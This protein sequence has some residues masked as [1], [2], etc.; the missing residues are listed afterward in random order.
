V[1]IRGDEPVELK[2][3]PW[4]L[5]GTLVLS[6]FVLV[7]QN[8][9]GLVGTVLAAALAAGE[10]SFGF[11]FCV[12]NWISDPVCLALI[13]SMARG[14]RA[15][16][17]RDYLALRR[18]RWLPLAEWIGGVILFAIIF[19]VLTYLL[20]LRITSE[21]TRRLY[22]SAEWP[23]L[24]WS[25]VLVAGPV[26]E[27]V[28]FR[29]FMFCGIQTSRLGNAGAVMV[30]SLAWAGLHLQYDWRYMFVVFA[31]GLMLGIARL[32]TGSVYTTI[33]MHSTGNLIAML[34]VWWNLRS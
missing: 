1:N 25:V 17:L 27:E 21:F 34:L 7:V 15:I 12:T 31:L 13:A 16:S 23:P 6:L 26:F 24:L 20:G 28:F 22:K 4:G 10:P 11:E 8:V 18:V 19:E 14:C 2:F 9:L 32:R 5:W 29:G 30:T 33:A 3:G